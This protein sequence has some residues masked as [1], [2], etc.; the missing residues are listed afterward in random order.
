MCMRKAK[1]KA[2]YSRHKEPE[3]T[4]SKATN[5]AATA[6]SHWLQ[7]LLNRSSHNGTTPEPRAAP[8]VSRRSPRK[9]TCNKLLGMLNDSLSTFSPVGKVVLSCFHSQAVQALD[10]LGLIYKDTE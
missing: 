8:G 1:R 6:A 4:R 3:I 10:Y 9:L 5:G 7:T 2:T